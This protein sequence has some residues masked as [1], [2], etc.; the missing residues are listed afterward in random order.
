MS[1]GFH[2]K[3]RMSFPSALALGV[4]GYDEVLELEMNESAESVD[5]DALL[6]DLNRCSIIGLDFYSARLLDEREK[7]A[8]LVT[9]TFEM[10]VPKELQNQT[11]HQISSFLSETTVIA[12]KANGKQVEVRSAVI[13]LRLDE[14]TGLLTVEIRT[15][16]G[17]EA[18]IREVLHVL[19]LDKELF[20]S[21][22]PKRI[23]C[24]LTEETQCP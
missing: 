21:V 18:G 5:P 12:E 24:R 23:R 13:E 6:A 15:Q 2:P 17:P 8:Q 7:K 16:E 1:G 20:K 19:Q 22:F 14:E 9:S 3:I 11:R 4:E 10:M